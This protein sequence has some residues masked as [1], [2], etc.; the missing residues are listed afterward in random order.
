MKI[1][2]WLII[3]CASLAIVACTTINRSPNVT[4]SGKR[5]VAVLPFTNNTETIQA[6]ERAQAIV[7]N[8]LQTYPRLK[9]I[10]YLQTKNCDQ[11]L[12]CKNQ[13]VA[14]RNAKRWALAKGATYGITGTV[15][16]WRYKVGLDG[17]PAVSLTLSLVNLRNNRVVWSS[18]SSKT[19]GS[20]SG[21]GVTAQ[22]LINEALSNVSWQ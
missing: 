15:N 17:E 22:E 10:T 3:A 1:F 21:L 11:L 8:L 12:Q 19:C 14:L 2:K 6:S 7:T 4:L 16:E 9:V 5:P 13:Q 18:V 20:R